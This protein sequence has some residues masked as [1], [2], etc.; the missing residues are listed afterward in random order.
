MFSKAVKTEL[1]SQGIYMSKE[2]VKKRSLGDMYAWFASLLPKKI[3]K[4]AAK[5]PDKFFDDNQKYFNDFKARLLTLLNLPYSE[6]YPA[7]SQLYTEI[8]E[9]INDPDA[10]L[11]AFWTANYPA[12]YNM[13]IKGRNLVRAL[14]IAIELYIIKTKIKDLPSRLPTDSPKDLFSDDEFEYIKTDNYFILGSQG[15]DAHNRTIQYRF[16]I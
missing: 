15:E 8:K 1:D 13:S 7:I 3:S 5:K 11:A 14:L 2:F 4:L 16:G 6:A 10:A 9:R 12:V